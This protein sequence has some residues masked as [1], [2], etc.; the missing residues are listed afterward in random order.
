M[1]HWTKDVGD[2]LLHRY[3]FV[4]LPFREWGIG[5]CRMRTLIVLSLQSG[6]SVQKERPRVV[7]QLSSSI[8]RVNQ[9]R[10]T[11]E[12]EFHNMGIAFAAIVS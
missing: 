12:I 4:P 7:A 10:R 8:Q 2:L 11:S 3:L 9:L 6:L 5:T 1:Q